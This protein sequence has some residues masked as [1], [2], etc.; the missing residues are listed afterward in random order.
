MEVS[1]GFKEVIKDY[2][3]SRAK[4]DKMFLAT[5]RKENKDINDCIK[6]IINTVHKQ[7]VNGL[8]DAEVY[9][10]AVHYYDEDD[11]DVGGDIN[12]KVLVNHHLELTAEEIEQEKQRAREQVFQAQMQKLKSKDEKPHL[13]IVKSENVASNE[14]L[15]LF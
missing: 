2:L 14:P 10:L 15:T 11:I 5:L 6:Y 1:E 3:R 9:G 12:C 4:Q 13:T 7:K 8:S